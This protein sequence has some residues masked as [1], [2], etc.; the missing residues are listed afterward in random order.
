M[1]RSNYAA[2]VVAQTQAHRFYPDSARARGEEGAV[3]VSFTIGPSG[4]VASAA[5]VR[6]SG[7][8]ELDAR[9]T[10]APVRFLLRHPWRLLFCERDNPLPL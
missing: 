4:S 2:L 1:S 5:V 6:S 10:K 3:G 9:R 7:F 8:A